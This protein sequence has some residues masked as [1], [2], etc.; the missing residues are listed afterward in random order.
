MAGS[1]I[2]VIDFAPF[3]D[4][5]DKKNVANAILES[6]KSIGFVYLINHGLPT[7][8]ITKMFEVVRIDVARDV[9]VL[10][11]LKMI[12]SQRSCSRSQWRS[13]NWPLTPSLGPITEARR[14]YL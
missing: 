12:F 11:M 5:S 10:M 1:T 2:D 13:S 7:R 14:T 8:K 3:L 4:G 9:Y 6:L